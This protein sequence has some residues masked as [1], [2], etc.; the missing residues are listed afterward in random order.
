M[1]D[2][3]SLGGGL[4][5]LMALLACLGYAAAIVALRAGKSVDMMPATCLAGFVAFLICLSLVGDVAISRHDLTIALL[6][7]TAQIGLQYLLITLAA[8]H[9]PAAQIA[10]IML[11]EVV[12]GPL[13]VWLG[14]GEVP[15]SATLFGGAIVLAAVLA[16]T[17]YTLR[18]QPDG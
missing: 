5:S 3:L 7:G 14:V 15:S 18:T 2:G 6:L 1:A 4:G 11:S 17:L 9:V 12:L 13:W 10:L 8:R 16:Q